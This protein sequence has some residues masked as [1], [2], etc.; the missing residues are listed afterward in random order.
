MRRTSGE[1]HQ[2]IARPLAPETPHDQL[3]RQLLVAKYGSQEDLEALGT[4][5][6]ACRDRVPID[7]TWARSVRPP[8]LPEQASR[9]R[10][11]LKSDAR[12]VL[13]ARRMGAPGTQRP[14]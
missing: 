11:S 2:G 9:A 4:D 10:N 3:A 12:C 13:R 5:L 8:V 7:L 1:T 14:E 6:A